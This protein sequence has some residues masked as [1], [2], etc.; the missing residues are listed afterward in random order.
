[1]ASM[2]GRR[3]SSPPGR[4]GRGGYSN[5]PVW[6]GRGPRPAHCA[7]RLPQTGGD[8][9]RPVSGPLQNLTAPA[10]RRSAVLDGAA[11]RAARRADGAKPRTA[12]HRPGCHRPR[13]AAPASASGL[14]NRDGLSSA[15]FSGIFRTGAGLPAGRGSRELRQPEDRPRADPPG[16]GQGGENR[17]LKPRGPAS[18]DKQ[19]ALQTAAGKGRAGRVPPP[20]RGAGGEIQVFRL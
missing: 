13:R 14:S 3:P 20:Q 5:P 19:T 7:R 10:R 18:P 4:G 17:M 8:D 1:M 12:T 9:A 11:G 2:A 15:T 6:G 16:G